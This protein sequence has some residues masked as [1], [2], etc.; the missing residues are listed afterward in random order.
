MKKLIILRG[1]P[2]SGKSTKAKEIL[3]KGPLKVICSADT[4]M[5]NA[6]GEYIF[7]SKKLERCHT[8]CKIE[9]RLS[10][11]NRIPVI[12]IDNTNI[13]KWEYQYYLDK[14]KQCNYEVEIQIVGNLTDTEMYWKRNI[15]NVPREV[16]ER[17]AQ[18]F[19]P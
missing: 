7:D 16:I 9:A 1:L 8:A 5:I 15:H 17:M 4:F 6:Q 14:A 18:R 11:Y 2:G 19:E 12:V 13:Q 3:P 10:M